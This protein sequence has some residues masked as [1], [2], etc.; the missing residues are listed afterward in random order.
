[1]GLPDNTLQKR[2]HFAWIAKAM[3]NTDL[4]EDN[5]KQRV[6][7][8]IFSKWTVQALFNFIVSSVCLMITAFIDDVYKSVEIMNERMNEN[9]GL[10]EYLIITKLIILHPHPR[11]ILL[12]KPPATG[13]WGKAGK[14]VIPSRRNHPEI[15]IKGKSPFKMRVSQPWQFLFSSRIVKDLH[16]CQSNYCF[17]FPHRL[18]GA[19]SFVMIN[20]NFLAKWQNVIILWFTRIERIGNYCNRN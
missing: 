5:F 17:L 14:V 2:F 6:I 16:L 3:E 12:E 8:Y 9:A 19:I 11:F 7:E 4:K 18:C 15:L 13:H 10:V 20:R 1:M